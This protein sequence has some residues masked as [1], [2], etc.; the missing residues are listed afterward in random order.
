MERPN[1]FIAVCLLDSEQ[2][3][4]HVRNTGR[5]AELLVRGARVFLE[6]SANPNRKTAYSL[7]AVYKGDM[8]VNNMDSQAPNKIA[9][10]AFRNGKLALPPGA[11]DVAS[12][13]RC[14]DSRIDLMFVGRDREPVGF[15]EVKGVTLERDGTAY[16]P[17]APTQR[18]VKHIKE[19]EKAAQRGLFA[20]VL[21]VIQLKG[22]CR[23]KPNDRTHRAFGDAMRE[24]ERVMFAAYDCVVKE[25]SIALDRE[26]AIELT[27][28]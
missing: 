25:D 4:A 26:I 14:G 11:V 18:G 10:E 22:C 19:L 28:E 27:E 3:Q 23:M 13:K 12:E 1:R 7:I 20:E 15:C 24:A 8:L 17:D 16:F 6:K 2:I 5:C 9:L 21:F